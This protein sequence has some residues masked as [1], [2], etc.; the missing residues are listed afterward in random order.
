M[1]WAPGQSVAGFEIQEELGRGG[2]G[3]VYRAL[4]VETGQLCAIKTLALEADAKAQARFQREGLGHARVDAHPNVIRVHAAGVAGGRGY[5][6]L[7][8]AAG[9]DLKQRLRGGPL[10]P[11][12]AAQ[13]AVEVGRA[14]VHAH[15]RGVLHRDL[16]PANVLFDEEGRAKLVDFG[17]VRLQGEGTLT[18]TGSLLGTPAFMSPEQA[19]GEKA[20]GPTTDVYGLGALLYAALCGRPPHSGGSLGETL[21]K[22]FNVRPT[23]PSEVF[24]GVPPELDRICARALEKSPEDRFESVAVMVAALEA[25][26][27]GSS[28]AG[29]EAR[30]QRPV[31]VS[32]AL[33]SLTL[34]ALVLAAGLLWRTTTAMPE[35]TPSPTPSPSATKPP[36]P[37]WR[38][39]EGLCLQIGLELEEKNDGEF[40]TTCR[41]TFDL[42]VVE[43]VER[44]WRLRGSYV[45][46]PD[47]QTL[48]LKNDPQGGDL[49][50]YARLR[51]PPEFLA[52]AKDRR[53][54]E[55]VL[56]PY[57]RVA[58]VGGLG[59]LRAELMQNAPV[60]PIDRVAGDRYGSFLIGVLYDPS[61]IL[62]TLDFLLSPYAAGSRWEE[63][64]P[65]VL[66][67]LGKTET[68][69][70]V[71]SWTGE[72]L[73]SSRFSYE[74]E[75]EFRD[76]RLVKASL[77]QSTHTPGRIDIE[78]RV[79]I[80]L[81]V[82][83]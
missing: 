8:L 49:A 11:R 48:N 50:S 35:P 31:L 72:A 66:R 27:A 65:G 18:Q 82:V 59:P 55:I 34:F 40:K 70:G 71:P 75:A 14:L 25:Y 1:Q 58:E 39:R 44:G 68:L 13:V 16:K 62:G 60:T 17:L 56:T 53:E 54:L 6:V 10:E 20:I 26:L 57:G 33:F 81:R 38:L 41:G 83:E 22:V 9:G 76:G 19:E 63:R 52:R 51:F 43:R 69:R 3:V 24:A 47:L 46:G 21:N 79:A 32:G 15:A 29:V 5:L 23:P 67:A 4:H 80:S 77:F 78:T 64:E 36:P 42:E 7:E 12:A 74:G 73:G 30:K 28:K 45:I 37:R 61:R 2:M